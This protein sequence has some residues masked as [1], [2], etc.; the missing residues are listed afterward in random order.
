MGSQLQ[1]AILALWALSFLSFK[2]KCL[3]ICKDKVDKQSTAQETIFLCLFGFPYTLRSD[4][5][6]ASMIPV[7]IFSPSFIFSSS[8]LRALISRCNCVCGWCWLKLSCAFSLLL[9]FLLSRK[10]R[11]WPGLMSWTLDFFCSSLSVKWGRSEDEREI[12]G[13]YSCR[14]RYEGGDMC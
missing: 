9:V 12:W 7:S 2:L 10:V 14:K 1:T 5:L 8:R 6:P 13:L 3:T 11:K 4:K